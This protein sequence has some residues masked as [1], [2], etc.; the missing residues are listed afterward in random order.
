M[1]CEPGTRR[2]RGFGF[3]TFATPEAVDRLFQGGP[4][5]PLDGRMVEVKPAVPKEA[6]PRMRGPMGQGGGLPGGHN[7]HSRGGG[8]ADGGM[9][10]GSYSPHHH[11]Q[12]YHHNGVHPAAIAHYYQQAADAYAAAAAVASSSGAGSP[13]GGGGMYSPGGGSADGPYAGSF[14][15]AQPGP[16]GW[17][18]PSGGP[19]MWRPVPDGSDGGDVAPGGITFGM[20]PHDI[21]GMGDGSG[22]GGEYS[23]GAAAMYAYG[24]YAAN[25]QQQAMA[26]AGARRGAALQQQQQ[27]RVS[28]AGAPDGP[29]AGNQDEYADAHEQPAVPLPEPLPDDASDGFLPQRLARRSR[30]ASTER[31]CAAPLQEPP[32]VP[33]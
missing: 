13:G 12:M 32:Q 15:Y 26:M 17:G 10:G 5:H 6:L 3:V 11:Q 18:R 14:G 25:M 8:H 29:A 22:Y 16:G 20:M 1:L 23:D 24:A 21:R 9:Q 4:L 31:V 28:R 27:Q 2:S 30:G 19:P 33:T 7:L